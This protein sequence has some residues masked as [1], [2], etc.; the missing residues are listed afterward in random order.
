MTL[1]DSFLEAV[2]T[3]KLG[4]E[5]GFGAIVTLKEFKA[6]FRNIETGYVTSFMPAS[7]IENG[8]F[9]ATHTKFLFRIKKGVYR[10]HPEVIEEYRVKHKLVNDQSS[11]YANTDKQTRNIM[12]SH[13]LM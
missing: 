4:T 2:A 11:S 7:V 10:V 9:S 13:S 6:Y 8:Q 1:K 5:D 3:G 12:F